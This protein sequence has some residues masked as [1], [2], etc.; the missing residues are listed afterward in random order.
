MA[1]REITIIFELEPKAVQAWTFNIE[2]KDLEKLARKYGATG[3]SLLGD[4]ETIGEE[5][6]ETWK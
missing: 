2:E 6:K 3:S 5:I 4:A 1:S